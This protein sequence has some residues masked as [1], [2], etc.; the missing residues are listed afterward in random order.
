MDAVDLYYE[1]SVHIALLHSNSLVAVFSDIEFRKN[2]V[3]HSNAGF[4]LY[5]IIN[6]YSKNTRFILHSTEKS[7]EEKARLNKNIEYLYKGSPLFY[8][9]LCERIDSMHF[10]D[11]KYESEGKQSFNNFVSFLKFLPKLN[12][13]QINDLKA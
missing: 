3:L 6:E 4:E 5:D 7:F 1:D 8:R 2:G 9:N 12:P 10:F 11:L 13:T